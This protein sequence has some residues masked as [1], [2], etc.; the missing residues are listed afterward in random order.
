MQVIHKLLPQNWVLSHRIE[1]YNI[2]YT[3]SNSSKQ[4]FIFFLFFVRLR[5]GLTESAGAFS[6]P[7]RS[8][9]LLLLAQFTCLLFHDNLKTSSLSS[10]GG[11]LSLNS[12]ILYEEKLN[13]FEAKKWPDLAA[14]KYIIPSRKSW[15]SRLNSC[16]LCSPSASESD[17]DALGSSEALFFGSFWQTILV[18]LRQSIGATKLREHAV[19]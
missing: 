15:F 16:L 13:K 7:H 9:N 17:E 5:W 8:I 2:D 19:L 10:S 11:D 12:R 3:S 14:N 4:L 6:S 1:F 18:N